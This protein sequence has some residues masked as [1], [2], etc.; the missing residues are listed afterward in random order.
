[1]HEYKKLEVS[2]IEEK[3][4]DILYKELLNNKYQFMILVFNNKKYV[5]TKERSLIEIE[6]EEEFLNNVKK[7]C[8]YKTVLKNININVNDEDL[9][10]YKF[11]LNKYKDKMSKKQYGDKYYF[12]CIAVKTD[13][14]F[15]TTIRG[16]EN[17][18]EYTIVENVDHNKRLIEAVNKKAS[19]NAPL[20]DYLFTNKNVKSIVHLHDFDDDLPYY[21][22]A[23]PGT[24]KDSI[25]NNKTSF[26]IKYHGVIY[27][28]D[29]NGKML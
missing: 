13:K 16:K 21:E 15:I 1:M 9:N 25:R 2:N 7:D 3:N 17:F 10:I 27:L 6:N 22:Y 26:N 11:Y 8:Y 12:G 4:I 23:S 5:L 24:V 29:E 14:G 19:L 28:F 18:D 20:L